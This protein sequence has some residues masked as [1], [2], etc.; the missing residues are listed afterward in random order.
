[1]NHTRII[2]FL[3]FSLMILV[4]SCNEESKII[5]TS[6][7]ITKSDSAFFISKLNDDTIYTGVP[8][9]LE[10][11]WKDSAIYKFEGTTVYDYDYYTVESPRY[12]YILDSIYLTPR[13][14]KMDS[15]LTV[16]PGIDTF[17]IPAAIPCTPRT[18]KLLAAVPKQIGNF[19]RKENA[20]VDVMYLNA[21]SGLPSS[22]INCLLYSKSGLMWIGTPKGLSCFDGNFIKTYTVENGL[23]DDFVQELFEDS[24]GNLWIGTMYGGVAKFDGTNL[25]ILDKKSGLPVNTVN[26]I[27]EDS[28]GNIWLGMWGAGVSKFDGKTI[29][30]FGRN[31]GL[32]EQRVTS[33]MIDKEDHL[34]I[35][36]NGKSLYKYDGHKL[37]SFEGHNGLGES[38]LLSLFSDSK[39]RTWIGNWTNMRYLKEDTLWT[40]RSGPAIATGQTPTTFED[41]R[42]N[43]WIG[44]Q[45]AGILKYDDKT[46]MHL[47]E[48][49]GLPSNNV[50]D[51]CED[52]A[53]NIWFSTDGGGLC[54]YN[55]NSFEY[56]DESSGLRSKMVNAIM[57]TVEGEI[58][59]ATDESIVLFN[60]TTFL[61]VR[62]PDH[63]TEALGSRIYDIYQTQDST[64]WF[65][66]LNHGIFKMKDANVRFLGQ[67]NGVHDHNI[68]AFTQRSNGEIWMG[69][70]N[71][72]LSLLN[73]RG[74]TVFNASSGLHNF[75]ITDLLTDSNDILWIATDGEGI[76]KYDGTTFTHFT[77]NEGL[78]SN[79]VNGFYE[80]SFH[81]LWVL[82]KGG[83]NLIKN[84]KITSFS[85]EIMLPDK[86]V[87]SLLQDEDGNYWIFTSN[88]LLY[89]K[90][91]NDRTPTEWNFSD[92]DTK[93]FTQFDGLIG[94][95]FKPRSALI[96]SKNRIWFGTGKGLMMKNI[97]SYDVTPKVPEIALEG[98]KIN[99]HFIDYNDLGNSRYDSLFTNFESARVGIGE[100]QPFKNYPSTLTLPA[101]LN[102]LTFTFSAKGWHS[103][104]ITYSYRLEGIDAAWSIPAKETW[105]E[106]RNLS[107]GDYTFQLKAIGEAGVESGLT[108]YAFT[109]LPPWYHTWWAR[110]IFL[111]IIILG[112][113]LLIRWRTQQLKAKQIELEHKVQQRTVELDVK[114]KELVSQNS[115][116]EDQK[117]EA[118]K[119]KEEIEKQHTLLEETHKE[120]KDSINYAKRIQEAILPTN[121]FIDQ[122][123]PENFVLYKPKDV[124]AGDFYWIQPT[125]DGVLFSAADCTGHGVPGAMVSVVC[126][127]ALNRAVREFGQTSPEKI[128]DKTR[129][130]VLE[131]FQQN[132][133][134][135]NDGM[136][137]ALI[138]L[139][140]TNASGERL[141]S[142]SGAN[143][144]ITIIRNGE[145]IEIEGDKQPIGN[146]KD[147]KPF[148]LHTQPVQ[149]GDIIYLLTD[150]YADQFGGPKGKKLK[151]KVLKELLRALSKDPLPLQ[152]QKLASYLDEWKGDLEQLDDISIFGFKI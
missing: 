144:G 87:V 28:K 126:Y 48:V 73:E 10:G 110:I 59:F 104:K 61:Q 29:Q 27:R 89:L 118:E 134:Q 58:I 98:I 2:Y 116:I 52:A 141:L 82:T 1:M 142:F 70:W 138:H 143:N 129:E 151:S 55:P 127:N 71:V 43:I 121:E 66:A 103:D 33:I 67:H 148:T 60:D 125:Q 34:W 145:M 20:K 99:G 50:T 96:D 37:I 77:K 40:I 3:V 69:A 112:I 7:S 38:Y 32:L 64:V 22:Y 130:I 80:D 44:T 146:Y 4:L 95:D 152:K 8:F 124:V 75:V 101:D 86:D 93:L 31:F 39:D 140:E 6:A 57:E 62:T 94:T 111:L 115:I 49:A 45:Q 56:F 114:N 150:G 81:H 147:A 91:K 36:T 131:T 92:Y 24:R 83:I 128:L 30:T 107:Y 68:T 100:T 119:R 25:T 117:A 72:G 84:D 102:H 108:E 106:Y 19:R 132:N 23:P 88:G 54:R 113:R 149:K 122:Y 51:I 78:V 13:V 109:I 42:N 53:G 14:V 136:D 120:I 137:A 135:V 11:K 17:D 65:S 133:A 12:K 79:N 74:F 139:G 76:T 9:E 15:L 46:L 90:L 16:F 41:S 5:E 123:M 105:A 97:S 35:T 47:D 18:I 21:E 85:K 26:C 63:E